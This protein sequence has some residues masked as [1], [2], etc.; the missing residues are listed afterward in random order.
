MSDDYRALLRRLTTLDAEAAAHRDE[1]IQWH[2]QRVARADQAVATAD[3]D[4]RAAAQALREAQRTREA[5]DARASLLWSTFTGT[6]GARAERFGSTLPPPAVPRQRD[7]D[8]EEYLKEAESKARYLPPSR[9]FTG[10]TTVMFALFGFIGGVAGVAVN[11]ALRWAG[12]SAGGDWAVALPVVALI[13]MLVGPVLAVFGA[14]RVADR[15]GV[16]LNAA[17]VA[18]VLVAGLVTA[19]LLLA[20]LQGAQR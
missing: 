2:D 19:G 13:V 6:V 17:A 8:A 12:Q 14:K 18:T 7:R 11:Q 4:V 5:V 10:A 1:A 3:D 20:A 16:G 15:R 9:P